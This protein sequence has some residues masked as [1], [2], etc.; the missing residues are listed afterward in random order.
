MK[1]S[2]FILVSLLIGMISIIS[3]G[4]SAKSNMKINTD[5]SGTFSCKYSIC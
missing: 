3:S 1:K 5:G 2:K 4:C